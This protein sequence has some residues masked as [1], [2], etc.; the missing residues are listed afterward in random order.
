MFTHAATVTLF[1]ASS[2]PLAADQRIDAD[3]DG[4]GQPDSALLTQTAERLRLSLKLSAAP[5][6][7]AAVEFGVDPA[8]QDAVCRLPV[9]IT[10]EPLD[11]EPE[12]V[13]LPGCNQQPPAFELVIEDGDCD[14]IRVYWNHEKGALS[15]WRR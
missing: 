11:C 4:D 15:W 8:R 2:A 13:L 10:A 3:L 6:S 14:A 9:R 7:V 12:G 5:Q 1:L